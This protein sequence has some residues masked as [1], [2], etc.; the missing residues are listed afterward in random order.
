LPAARLPDGLNF[1]R[2]SFRSPIVSAGLHRGNASVSILGKRVRPARLA[3]AILAATVTAVIVSSASAQTPA[4]GEKAQPAPA[5]PPGVIA[6]WNDGFFVQSADGDNR[7]Q[8]GVIVQAD[9]RF[10][11][12]DPQVVVDTFV[13]RKA[14]P[15]LSGRIARYVD[16]KLMP[17]F[18]QGNATALD[19]YF[20]IRFSPKLRVRSGKDKTPVGYEL[21][22]SDG[23]LIFPER[24]LVSLL[25]PNR[26]VGFQAIGE[27]AGGTFL[28][29]GGVFNGQIDATS[30][31]TDVDTNSAKDLAGRVVVYPFRSSSAGASPLSSIGFHLGGS[32]GTQSGALPSFA[33]NAGQTYFGYAGGVTADG[34]RH[35]ITPAVFLYTKSFGGFF[36]YAH[37]SQ[38]LLR[39]GVH[40]TVTNNA[41]G[42]TGSY[43]LTGEPTSDRGVRPRTPFDPAAGHWGA[44]QIAARYAQLLLDEDAITAGLVAATANTDA[45]QWS[46]GANWYPTSFVKA[47][48]TFERITLRG[49]DATDENTI[50]FRMQLSF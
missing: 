21:L 15:V 7:L 42:I 48:A 40:T 13:L 31:R 10:F 33:R 29:Q 11:P 46:I 3:R 39:S 44:F 16:F 5:K 38:V 47:Y 22:I 30:T 37:T 17:E 24:T 9:G 4:S 23:S 43:V 14:R 35:R 27:L 2:D 20:D 6:G 32:T 18:A 50:I 28:Y 45:R 25:V 1:G 19:A 8:L 49:G 34:P 26:D 36:E 12:D 41:W